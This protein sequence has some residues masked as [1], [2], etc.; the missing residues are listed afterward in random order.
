MGIITIV[1]NCGWLVLWGNDLGCDENTKNVLEAAWFDPIRTA[2]TGRTLGINSMQDSGLVLIL[3]QR[4]LVQAGAQMILD[5]AEVR[6]ARFGRLEKVKTV[7][8]Q[9]SFKPERKQSLGG[10]TFP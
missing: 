1:W 5:L 3:S 6:Q 10:P 4:C 7:Q 2:I 8:K 9:L